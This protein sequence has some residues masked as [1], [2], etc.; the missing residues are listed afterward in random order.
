MKPSGKQMKILTSLAVSH[1]FEAFFITRRVAKS[2]GLK[3]GRYVCLTL[4]FGFFVWV[5]LLRKPKVEASA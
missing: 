3:P 1:V 4:V 5:P 2:R